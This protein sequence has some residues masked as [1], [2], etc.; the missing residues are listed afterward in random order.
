MTDQ[1]GKHL[2][3][4]TFTVAENARDDPFGVIVEDRL[5]NAAKMRERAYVPLAPGFAR[6]LRYDRWRK[7]YSGMKVDQSKRLNDL[8]REHAR[9]KRLVVGAKLDK[10]I[11]REAGSG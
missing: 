4:L 9:M 2:R 6:L 10:A 7:D 3:A 11:V 5:W 8:E 1:P